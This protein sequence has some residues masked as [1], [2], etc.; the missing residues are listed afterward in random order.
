MQWP[1]LPRAFPVR[2]TLLMSAVPAI[3]LTIFLA[4]F[5]WGLQPLERYYLPTYWECSERAK[6]SASTTQIEWLFKSAPGRNS[7]PVIDVD[8]ASDGL[9]SPSLELSPSAYER[10]WI[11]LEKGRPEAVNS[12]ELE[13]LLQEDFYGSR[14]FRQVIAEPLLYASG[15]PV[16]VLYVAFMM[17]RELGIEWNRLREEVLES[18]S[19][20]NIVRTWSQ[21]A[22]R[23]RTWI[24]R[25]I[26]VEKAPL[27]RGN[28]AVK[29]VPHAAVILDTVR[30]AEARSLMSEKQYLPSSLKEPPQRRSIF[31]GRAASVHNTKER[32]KPW[33]ESQWI[34]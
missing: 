20:F 22:R 28:S 27:Q 32:S 14:N 24:G 34:D 16:L 31:P 11:S 8:V 7:E 25:R 26:A 13:G 2:I 4:W 21:F 10:G 12:I 1:P 18:E 9:R 3:I 33:D 17:K 29:T 19:T 6:Q 5:G 23:I 30:Q 15:V